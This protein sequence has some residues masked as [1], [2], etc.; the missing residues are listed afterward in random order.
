MVHL[1]GA[2]R[3]VLGR[4][5]LVPLTSIIKSPLFYAIYKLFLAFLCRL[6][7]M[8]YD[9]VHLLFWLS[10][11]STNSFTF[12]FLMPRACLRMLGTAGYTAYPVYDSGLSPTLAE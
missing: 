1:K 9:P 11:F 3:A 7:S 12:Y 8:C 5:V 6:R 2:D 10:L 4:C